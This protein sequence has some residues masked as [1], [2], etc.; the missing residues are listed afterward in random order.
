M[1]AS[2]E[3]A[4]HFK[5]EAYRAHDAPERHLSYH[6]VNLDLQGLAAEQEDKSEMRRMLRNSLAARGMYEAPQGTAA[7]VDIHFSV[8]VFERY[9]PA[10]DGYVQFRPATHHVRNV[11]VISETA[12]GRVIRQSKRA[13]VPTNYGFRS[14]RRR[15]D[16]VPVYDKTLNISAREW[17]ETANGRNALELWRVEVQNSDRCGSA[18]TYLPLMLSAALG[19]M[20]KHSDTRIEVAL[21][22]SDPSVQLVVGD[23]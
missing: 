7:E 8:S 23:F 2:S 4:H 15:P 19:V 12:D 5:I 20:G 21:N 18:G 3:D 6:I 11:D 17:T 13:I 1:P 16:A 14:T 22:S 9:Q 10:V